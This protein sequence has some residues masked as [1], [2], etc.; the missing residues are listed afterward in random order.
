MIKFF[1]HTTSWNTK[2]KSSVN[3][4]S[5]VGTTSCP[6]VRNQLLNNHHTKWTPS[7]IL[8]F[9]KLAPNMRMIRQQE[10]TSNNVIRLFNRIHFIMDLFQCHEYL[11]LTYTWVETN[12]RTHSTTSPSKKLWRQFHLHFPTC[13][14]NIHI[15]STITYLSRTI[16]NNQ[17]NLTFK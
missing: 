17:L 9:S 10:S 12:N 16:P 11:A 15:F 7:T 1:F 14:S 5:G 6:F 2:I 4:A 8:L 13:H 3:G